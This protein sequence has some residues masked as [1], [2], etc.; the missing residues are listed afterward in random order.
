[1]R[2]HQAYYTSR[3][4]NQSNPFAV[5]ALTLGPADQVFKATRASFSLI[6][7]CII[8]LETDGMAVACR[9]PLCAQDARRAQLGRRNKG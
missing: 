9:R 1:M 6:A 2:L 4:H 3:T 5:T 8:E 7:S